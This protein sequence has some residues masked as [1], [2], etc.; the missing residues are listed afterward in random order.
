MTKEEAK[1]MA[2]IFQ[3]I[4]NICELTENIANCDTDGIDF[5]SI[6]VNAIGKEELINALLKYKDTLYQSARRDISNIGL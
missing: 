2:T 1:Q 6:L 3:E 4:E 5:Y